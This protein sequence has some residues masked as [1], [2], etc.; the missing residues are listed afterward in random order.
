MS[1][2]STISSYIPSSVHEKV[3]NYSTQATTA[4]IFGA[5]GYLF[6]TSYNNFERKNDTFSYQH[7]HAFAA[8]GAIAGLA[9]LRLHQR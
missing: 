7:R 8:A 9:L 2:I 1:L 4:T 5:L 6:A 3:K